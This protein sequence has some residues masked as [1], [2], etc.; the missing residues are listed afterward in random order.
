MKVQAFALIDFSQYFFLNQVESTNF[1]LIFNTTI[2]YFSTDRHMKE[3]AIRSSIRVEIKIAKTLFT[4]V[5]VFLLSVL[6]SA[7]VQLWEIS[8]SSA[9]TTDL[10][11]FSV[12]KHDTYK[13]VSH[14]GIVVLFYNSLWNYFI[15]QKR[16][17]DFKKSLMKVKKRLLSEFCKSGFEKG[18]KTEKSGSLQ[19][20]KTVFAGLSE[21]MSTVL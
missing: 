17:G 4:M 5:S 15:Y 12:N 1:N 11:N 9:C 18:N 8:D 20:R 16:D 21:K 6:P 13:K 14:A 19:S 3:N 2:K 10:K 7:I